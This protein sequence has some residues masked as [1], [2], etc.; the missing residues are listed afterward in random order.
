MIQCAQMSSWHSISKGFFLLMLGLSVLSCDGSRSS[1]L[2]RNSIPGWSTGNVFASLEEVIPADRTFAWRIDTPD[3]PQTFVWISADG[4]AITGQQLRKITPQALIDSD[5]HA[6][7]P[8][9]MSGILL[10]VSDDGAVVSKSAVYCA[11]ENENVRCVKSNVGRIAIAFIDAT[12]IEGAVFSNSKDATRRYSAAF[13][14][15]VV[16]QADTRLVSKARWFRN[17]SPPGAAFMDFMKAAGNKDAA[18]MR[19]LSVS[20]RASD[21][22]H[23]GLITSMW[24]FAQK[25]PVVIAASAQAD[26][27]VLWVLQTSAERFPMLP[28]EVRMS[29]VDGVWRFD[30]M[31][32]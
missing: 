30:E 31:S 29:L 20:K 21:W 22:D 26:S 8:F 7:G 12:R 23:F 27:A 17:G 10:H 14:T 11:T 16:N 2:A 15:A 32:F 3:G 4:D 1:D 13:D 19:S 6:A 25:Q 24:R 28:A 5:D 18:A 9:G